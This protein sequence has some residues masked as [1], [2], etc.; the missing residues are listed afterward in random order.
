M[1]KTTHEL[2][3]QALI[4]SVYVA[5]TFALQSVSFMPVQFRVSE[6]MLILVLFNPKHALGLTVGT[7]IANSFSTVSVID[8]V[9]GSLATYISLWFM[10]YLKNKK[11]KYLAP[12]VFNGI[13]VGLM[14]TLVLDLP[15]LYSMFS[16]FGS[17]LVVTFVPWILIG[18]KVLNNDGM[19]RI[20]G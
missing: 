20:F 11:M 18:D 19:K 14:L 16:V 15:L 17:E 8:I 7:V 4:A 12:A 9:V 2:V 1:K 3:L 6:V 5:V 13:I 10:I